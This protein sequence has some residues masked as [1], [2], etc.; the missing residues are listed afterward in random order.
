MIDQIRQS[1]SELL[2]TAVSSGRPVEVDPDPRPSRSAFRRAPRS[3]RARPRASENRERI[4]EALRTIV[5]AQLK[6]VFVLLEGKDAEAAGADV[7]EAER[8]LTEEEV[9]DML[10]SEFDAEEMIDDPEKPPRARKETS[11]G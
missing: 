9:L 5:G 10:E 6:P 3:P 4:A 2:S 11:D 8:Q 7:D 1:G